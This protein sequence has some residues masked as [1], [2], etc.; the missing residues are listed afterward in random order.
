MYSA[1]ENAAAAAAAAERTAFRGAEKRYK[2]YKTL[3]HRPKS[4]KRTTTGTKPTD[5]SD[6]VDFKAVLDGFAGGRDLPPGILRFDCDGFDRPVFCIEDRPGFFFIPSALTI[7][8][9]CYWIRESLAT[10][11]QPPNRANL[12]A[13]YGPIYGL[14]NAAQNQKVLIET[15]DTDTLVDHELNGSKSSPHSQKFLFA[16]TSDVHRVETCKSIAALAL[17]KKLRWST[18]GLQFDWSKRNYDVSLPHN[19]IPDA[20]CTLA[21]KMAVPALP[22][23]EDF[24]PEA[25]IVN[26]FG[27]SDMLGGH[28]DD[29]EL[30]WTRPIVSISLGCKAI[31]LLGGKTR[32]DVPIAMFL[33][34]GD[35]V[36]MAGE[37][38]ECFHGVPRIFTD[39]DHAEISAILSQFSAE[40]DRCYADYIRNSRI[41]INIRQ[42]N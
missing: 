35:I 5:L 19:K 11:P 20:L 18:L 37:A 9:Q 26:Y 14:F 4:R 32:E 3:P 38:R 42:V 41:N 23:G 27:P 17:L 22:F 36:L 34:S 33:R 24:H 39:D 1:A 8:E 6:V 12:T 7:E 10:F 28:L 2:L 13:I 40:D 21:R 16:E 31:F 30:D 15:E 29:M 25:A